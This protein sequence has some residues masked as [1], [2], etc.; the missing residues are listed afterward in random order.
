MSGV[1]AAGVLLNAVPASADPGTPPP[2]GTITIDGVVASG[3]SCRPGTTALAISPDRTAFTI[4]YSEFLAQVGLG[5]TPGD[6]HK[7]CMLHVSVQTPSGYTYAV[8]S[9]DYRGFAQLASGATAVEHGSYQLQGDNTTTEASH[10]IA[11]P[12]DDDWQTSDVASGLIYVPCGKQRKL[13]VT[14]ELQANAGTS[15]V[16]KTTSFISMDSTDVSIQSTYHFAWK[17]C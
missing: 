4:T 9:V 13:D 17:R 14:T 8:S 5:T 16:K 7:K 10:T 3:S 2:A 12:F 15:D 6:S 1:I 11:G